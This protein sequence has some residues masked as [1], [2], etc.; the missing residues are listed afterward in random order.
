MAGGSYVIRTLYWSYYMPN[1]LFT[2]EDIETGD[3][4]DICAP[5]EAAARLQ[6][7]GIFTDI[8]RTAVFGPCPIGNLDR[9]IEQAIANER[10]AHAAARAANPMGK[11]RFTTPEALKAFSDAQAAHAKAES[12]VSALLK[13]R[14]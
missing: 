1:S 6:L 8:E 11:G 5:N 3:L 14:G 9:V 10:A 2:F 12:R 4:W 7:G 13:L